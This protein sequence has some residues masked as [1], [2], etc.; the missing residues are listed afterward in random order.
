M[1]NDEFGK[2]VALH[3]NVLI[4]G[5]PGFWLEDV[6]TGAAYVFELDTLGQW[7]ETKKLNQPVRSNLDRFGRAVA[8]SE[9]TIAVGAPHEDQDVQEV[10]FL[11]TSGS[12]YLYVKEGFSGDWILLEKVVADDRSEGALFGWSVDLYRGQLLVGAPGDQTGLSGDPFVVQTGS[13]YYFHDSV[14]LGWMQDQKMVAADREFEDLF[15][16]EVAISGNQA[17]IAAPFDDLDL[18]G[19][20]LLNNAGAVYFASSA[21]LL[22]AQPKPEVLLDLEVFPNPTSGALAIRLDRPG[23]NLKVRVYN[24]HGELVGDFEMGNS[25]MMELEIEG[26]AGVYLVE[27]RDEKG[28]GAIKK[29]LKR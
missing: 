9:N 5:A 22:T 19:S 29:V 26:T 28:S 18:N 3:G 4:V 24:L 6:T 11:N 8:V 14:G 10:N 1:T 23:K 20:N 27:V 16:Y 12:V 25:V 7:S 2:S 17:I 13:A 15:G 21:S